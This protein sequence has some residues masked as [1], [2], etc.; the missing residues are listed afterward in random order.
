MYAAIRQ[1]KAKARVADELARTI[2]EGANPDHQRCPGLQGLL[3][4]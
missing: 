2:K 3:R 1:V 4:D